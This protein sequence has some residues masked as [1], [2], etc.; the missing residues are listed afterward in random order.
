VRVLACMKVKKCVVQCAHVLL[1]YVVHVLACMKV[2]K[3]A[4]QCAHVLLLYVVR[5]LVCMKVKKPNLAIELSSY[6]EQHNMWIG[7]RQVRVI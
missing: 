3:C 5:V 4:V 1:L 7:P 6:P 2:K